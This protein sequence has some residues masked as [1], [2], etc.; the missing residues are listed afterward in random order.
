MAAANT[1]ICRTDFGRVANMTRVFMK[2]KKGEEEK[3]F[4]TFEGEFWEEK[5]ESRPHEEENY[6]P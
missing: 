6:W 3:P 2:R 4:P 5:R 1:V